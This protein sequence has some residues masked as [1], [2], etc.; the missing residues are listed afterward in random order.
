MLGYPED[1]RDIC[2]G[3]D[4]VLTRAAPETLLIDF[5]TSR[6]DL[7]REIAV[8]AENRGLGSVDAPVSGGDRGAREATLSIMAGGSEEDVTRAM[9][10]LQRLGSNVVH[11]GPAGS[12]QRTKLCNQIAIASNMLGV[13]EA[14]V[15]AR[16]GGLDPRRVL[17]S[18]EHGA[19]GSWSLSN[20]APRIL[21]G[22]L[23]P[24]FYVHHF[25]KDMAMALETAIEENLEL[26]GLELALNRYRLLA[27]QGGEHLGTQGLIELYG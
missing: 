15:F 13:C 6:P 19:A 14:L 22:D 12:G 8:L 27:R 21:D 1:V 26:P 17:S 24:G 5:T 3:E 9:P 10:L 11:Q 25:I 18:I 16:A 20:L 23:A 4:G 2:L 7:A